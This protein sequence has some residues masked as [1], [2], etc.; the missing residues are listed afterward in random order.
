MEIKKEVLVTLVGGKEISLT[1]NNGGIESFITWFKAND[2]GTFYVETVSGIPGEVN[3][4]LLN[5]TAIAAIEITIIH[6]SDKDSLFELFGD[7]NYRTADTLR[8]AGYNTVGDL[9]NV[10]LSSIGRKKG[11]GIKTLRTIY[12]VLFRHGIRQPSEV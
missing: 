9:R 1:L 4:T 2:V 6:L 12:N 5:K 7:E 3:T 8:K 11:I 10:T